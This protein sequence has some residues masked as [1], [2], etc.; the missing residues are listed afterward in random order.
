M[1]IACVGAACGF[2]LRNFGNIIRGKF[3]RSGQ[4]GARSD[5]PDALPFLLNSLAA[6]RTV[7]R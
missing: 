3:M 7:L 1:A 2:E 6:S 5:W 4:P